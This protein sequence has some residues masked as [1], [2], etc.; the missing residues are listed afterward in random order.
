MTIYVGNYANGGGLRDLLSASPRWYYTFDG[1]DDQ[2]TV[3]VIALTS[4][5]SFEFDYKAPVGSGN[6]VMV[7]PNT[8]SALFYQSGTGLQK[9]NNTTVLLDGIAVTN[10]QT[11]PN[12]D[13]WH[14]VKV[15]LDSGSSDVGIIGAWNASGYFCDFPIANVR[16]TAQAG[17]RFYPL[18]DQWTLG[19]NIAKDWNDASMPDEAGWD[20]VDGIGY[21]RTDGTNN[22][23]V[24]DTLKS[25]M[26]NGTEYTFVVHTEGQTSGSI[27]FDAGGVA[28]ITATSAQT[29]YE[30][31]RTATANTG[32]FFQGLSNNEMLITRLE[33]Y[34]SASFQAFADTVGGQGATAPASLLERANWS[35]EVGV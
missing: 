4:G 23:W 34:P 21:T 7:S 16:I 29:E 8:G 27:A 11:A 30:F 1:V 12:D 10:G 3:P 9:A 32:L 33:V 22:G 5:D 24:G 2:I 14:H 31:I 25:V 6:R 20:F 28:V 17:N 18:N 26:S 13:E 19:A 35:F 15:T